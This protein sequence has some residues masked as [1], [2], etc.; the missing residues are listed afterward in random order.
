MGNKYAF[1]LSQKQIDHIGTA[2]K[3]YESKNTTNKKTLYFARQDIAF[4]IKYVYGKEIWWKGRRKNYNHNK[5]YWD[6]YQYQSKRYQPI[7]YRTHGT[8][9]KYI[10]YK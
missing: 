8:F 9:P 6:H 5:D 2:I 1:H 10:P 3:S 7:L 4:I